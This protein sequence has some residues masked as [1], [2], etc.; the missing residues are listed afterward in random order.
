MATDEE[1]IAEIKRTAETV[2]EMLAESGAPAE[3]GVE[4]LRW[5]EQLLLKLRG[6]LDKEGMAT[7]A[8]AVGS[9]LG[10]CMCRTYGGTW[11]KKNDNW[12]VS[13][14]NG[15]LVLLPFS[16]VFALFYGGAEDSFVGMFTL[17]PRLLET[18][19]KE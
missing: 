18:P 9:F 5:L 8:N 13:L 17:I 3:Y 14:G 7:Y 15:R 19:G 16:K 10:E 11:V 6:T 4:A 2:F 12:G 1:T